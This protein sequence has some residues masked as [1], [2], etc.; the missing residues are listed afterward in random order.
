MP[1]PSVVLH[2][3]FL[4]PEGGGRLALVLARGL[5]M[6][7]ECGFVAPGHPFFAEP[8]PG[9]ITELGVRTRLPLAMQWSLARAFMHRTEYLKGMD[10]AVYSGSYAP[11][12]AL[13]G[14]ARRNVCYCH[15]PPRFLYDRRD[16]FLRAA[17]APAWPLL[18]A[19]CSWLRPR[20]EKAMARMDRIIANSEN[21]RR[22]IRDFLGLEA[23]VVHPPCDVAGFRWIEAGDFFLS[24][25]RLDHLKRVDL[26][27][28]AFAGMP[29]QRLV[30]VSGGP[31]LGRLRH[32]A[33]G[34][35]NVE[36]RGVV[37][38]AELRHLMGCCRATVYVPKD[39][40]F[41]MTPVESMAAGKPVVGVA[42]GGL[43]ETVLPG[44]TGFLLEP[45]PTPAGLAKAVLGLTPERAAAMR[46][47]CEARARVFA[48]P[49][50]LERMRESLAWG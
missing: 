26:V 16:D 36:V 23:E 45:D 40:D 15:T 2:D 42:Q 1:E 50:F 39:E 34:L 5:G 29:Q 19:F 18:R 4:Q 22:R 8:F 46:P 30:V 27:V 35:D 28:Q 17:P 43:L 48:E 9:R 49:V 3:Y 37:S 33:S 11:L 38:E 10:L 32:A 7:L 25:A 44:E 6:D 24:A 20:Y 13:A 21:V 41:G 47:A 14:G 12:A 31:D